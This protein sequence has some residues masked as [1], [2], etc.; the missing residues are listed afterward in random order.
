MNVIFISYR[1][2]ETLDI[3]GRVDDWLRNKFGKEAVFRDVRSIPPGVQ[4][5]ERIESAIRCSRVVL[6]VIGAHWLDIREE[7]QRGRRLDNP[8]DPVRK[9]VE[10]ALKYRTPIIP[11]L[12]QGARMPSE[13]ELP[14]SIAELARFN[15]VK[16][17]SDIDFEAH[18]E[19]LI[20]AVGAYF[21]ALNTLNTSPTQYHQQGSPDSRATQ[22]RKSG[23]MKAALLAQQAGLPTPEAIPTTAVPTKLPRPTAKS[24][25]TGSAP[26]RP[27]PAKTEMDTRFGPWLDV[28]TGIYNPKTVKKQ[29]SAQAVLPAVVRRDP[30]K[31]L[32]DDLHWDDVASGDVTLYKRVGAMQMQEKI[33]H[34]ERFQIM[35]H[36]VT[37]ALFEAFIEQGYADARWWG[38]SAFTRNYHLLDSKPVAAA[39]KGDT[40][41]REMVSWYEA[42]A[43]AA[44]LS[45]RTGWV[46]R[47]PS[48]Q[49]WQRA[50][51]GN[52]HREY[53]WGNEFDATKTNTLESK[54]GKTCPVEQ[55]IRGRSPF[56]A[57]DMIGNLQQWCTNDFDPHGTATTPGQMQLKVIRG[58]AWNQRKQ[59]VMFRDKLAANERVDYVGFRL[60]RLPS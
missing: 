30:L 25:P 39:F 53:P 43:F 44:W 6:I 54:L 21:P 23:E 14:P 27:R 49:Q 3:V 28:G 46:L 60:V 56:K 58:A 22:P 20:H 59:N 1:R 24:T 55:N 57:F 7:H 42:W 29:S 5:I 18:M 51:Q 11:V 8:Q 9:E 4:F 26:P 40:L 45:D 41:P 16:V 36:L 52:D 38:H 15:A 33:A 35:R 12:V 10:F 32:I 47:L 17:N 2:G 37:N 34:V 50:A 48:E 13:R 19:R 31:K